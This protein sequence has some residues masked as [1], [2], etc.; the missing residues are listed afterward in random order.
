MCI[1][2]RFIFEDGPIDLLSLKGPPDLF[3][4]QFPPV[5]Q[6]VSNF[7]ELIEYWDTGPADGVIELFGEPAVDD[8]PS[9]LSLFGEIR[10]QRIVPEPQFGALWP[11]A[12][13]GLL[14]LT[15]SGQNTELRAA[16]TDDWRRA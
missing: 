15:R 5:G 4:S 6:N 1:R 12:V 13:I 7:T 3:L 11:I 16:S 10:S 9:L 8:S 14:R 2:D